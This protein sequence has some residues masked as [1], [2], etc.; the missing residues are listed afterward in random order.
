MKKNDGKFIRYSCRFPE[1]LAEITESGKECG[2]H[3]SDCAWDVN[4]VREESDTKNTKEQNR[5][6]I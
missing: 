5:Q 3:D 4:A 2:I 1:Q 6:Q